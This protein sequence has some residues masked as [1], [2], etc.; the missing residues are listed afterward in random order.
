V[1]QLG[2]PGRHQQRPPR[3]LHHH[4]HRSD[5]ISTAHNHQP[6]DGPAYHDCPACI[7]HDGATWHDI[8]G[9][10]DGT[11]HDCAVCDKY[12]GPELHAD[13]GARDRDSDFCC[14]T[15]SFLG[16]SGCSKYSAG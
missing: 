15:C 12:F 14:P 8:V 11:H 6:S 9:S 7:A 13:R 16:R 3:Q 10:H 1:G 2:R 5:D 4:D